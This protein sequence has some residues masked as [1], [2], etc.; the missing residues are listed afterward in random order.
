MPVSFAMPR[1]DRGTAKSTLGT[2]IDDI[3]ED[4]KTADNLAVVSKRLAEHLGSAWRGDDGKLKTSFHINKSS[5]YIEL[6]SDSELR[7]GISTK[8]QRTFIKISYVPEKGKSALFTIELDPNDP[9][10]VNKLKNEMFKHQIPFRINR[11]YLN[12]K[13][14]NLDYNSVIGE[15]ANTNVEPGYVTTTN[16][17]FTIAPVSPDGTVQKR[18]IK[19]KLQVLIPTATTSQP[20]ITY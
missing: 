16:N 15:L 9:E 11:K 5:K 1:Y 14:G 12:K 6:A 10:F 8:E 18:Q 17:W 19:L 4:L 2:I 7:S 3:L 20:T 13:I